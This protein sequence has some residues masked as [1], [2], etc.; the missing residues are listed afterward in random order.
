MDEKRM[1]R[2][3]LHRALAEPHRLEIVDELALSDRSPTELGHQLGMAS[4]LLAHHLDVLEAAGLIE[5]VT[6]TGDRRRRY[7]RL[8]RARLAELAAAT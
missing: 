1:R 5:R 2:A 8:C 4:N 7:L 6:S 3:Q